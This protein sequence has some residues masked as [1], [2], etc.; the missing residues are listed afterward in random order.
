MSDLDFTQVKNQQ[1]IAEQLGK[2]TWLTVHQYKREDSEVISYWCALAP[3]EYSTECIL[4]ES[5]WE[6]R[7]GAQRFSLWYEPDELPTYEPF[8]KHKW[9]ALIYRRTHPVTGQNWIELSD[10]FKLFY[11]L[12][13]NQDG[14]VFSYFKDDDNFEEVVRFFEEDKKVQ[15]KRNFLR[16]YLLIR[17]MRLVLYFE[18][19][20]HTSKE[21]SILFD[22]EFIRGEKHCYEILYSPHGAIKDKPYVS[23][24]TGKKLIEPVKRVSLNIW[25]YDIQPEQVHFEEFIIAQDEDGANI[26]ASCDPNKLA[27][28]FG[29]NSENPHDLSPV[30]FSKDV[31]GKYYLDPDK[32][33]ISDG[34]LRCHSSR[35]LSIDNHHQDYVM[36]YLGDLGRDLP[37]S[38]R[39]YW[40]AF[41]IPPEDRKMSRVKF[42]R[43]F[44]GAWSSADFPIH[45]FKSE[46]ERFN[47]D[48]SKKYGWPL[49][50][51][52]HNDDRHH[53]S[54][55]RIPINTSYAEFDSQ[56]LSL[57]RLLVDSI[58]EKELMKWIPDQK[59]EIFRDENTE[60]SDDLVKG[61]INKLEK[62]LLFFQQ[63]DVVTRI[64]LLRNIQTIR[65]QSGAH[66]KSESGFPKLMQRMNPDNLPGPDLFESFIV[67]SIELLQFLRQYLIDE[68]PAIL[69][70]SE[71]EP[72]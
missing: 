53:F 7:P 54:A 46:Y 49:F 32:Y 29:K 11:D 31:L 72:T 64:K 28:N 20:K 70:E 60:N 2:D 14:T 27:N 4:S 43:D 41:N 9:E 38:E 17:K 25:Q 24:V 26:K 67:Q 23:R 45:Q 59:S 1:F 42:E 71:G 56:I 33:E 61:G 40:L 58:N 6:V 34:T 39:K 35:Y 44:L 5:K 21:N 57:V 68:T 8:L 48:F 50:K 36:A 3:L 12:I 66:R 63:P 65:S 10:D 51:P 18:F 52:L 15:I 19:D 37:A 69:T 47:E 62:I 16:H 13:P 22:N 55:L 30:Y